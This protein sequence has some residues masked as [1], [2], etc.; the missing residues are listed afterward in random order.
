MKVTGY[1]YI[2]ETGYIDVY[3]EG[4]IV[5]DRYYPY[6]V[7]KSEN[8]PKI[9]QTIKSNYAIFTL[10]PKHGHRYIPMSKLA[11]YLYGID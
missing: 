10:N 1:V 5:E 9:G 11:K 3:K 7:M 8:F 6:A 4:V 2:L